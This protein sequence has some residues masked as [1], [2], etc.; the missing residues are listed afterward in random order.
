MKSDL[1]NV[2]LTFG[3]VVLTLSVGAYVYQ[4]REVNTLEATRVDEV[5]LPNNEDEISIPEVT[6]QS[7]E[8]PTEV[9][10]VVKDTPVAVPPTT[11][12]PVAPTPTQK[13][14]PV[15]PPPAVTAPVITTPTSVATTVTKTPVVKPSR[16]SHAS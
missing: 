15:T 14:V 4:G 2:L 1:R 11:S 6:T 7:P 8:T 12:T 9:I 5:I 3:A 16:N 13:A 10:E